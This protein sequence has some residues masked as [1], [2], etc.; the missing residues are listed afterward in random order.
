MLELPLFA[1]GPCGRQTISSAQQERYGF[2]YL[3][4]LDPYP[5]TSGPVIEELRGS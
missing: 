3:T 1:V 2:S 5:E 4:V